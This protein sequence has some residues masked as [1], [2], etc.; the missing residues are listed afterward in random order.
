MEGKMKK[1]KV[2]VLAVLVFGIFQ[3]ILYAGISSRVQGNVADDQTSVPVEGA[4]VHLI[5]TTGSVPHIML[6][7]WETKTDKNGFFKFDIEPSYLSGSKV[8]SIECEKTGYIP[9]LPKYYRQYTK[10]EVYD[11]IFKIFKL[12]EGQ[13]KH[14][15]IS[16]KKGGIIEGT[17]FKKTAA[18]VAP[19]KASVILYSKYK[20]HSFFKDE[21][22]DYI[23]E[24]CSTDGNGKFR[25]EGIEAFD[26]YSLSINSIGYRD[27]EIDN[28]AVQDNQ[29]TPFE[30]TCDMTDQTGVE[31]VVKINSK[32]LWG[33]EVSVYSD[34]K[35][36]E[37]K[38]VSQTCHFGKN[39]VYA[40]IGI[41]PGIYSVV[42][43]V[44]TDDTTHF[45]KELKIEIV[46]GITRKL[47]IDF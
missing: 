42:I 25:I 43:D 22:E 36:A 38:V 9:F 5:I 13:I 46:S 23:F 31:G 16:L 21:D 19:L 14:F 32:S 29:V 1:V 24:S 18:G 7:D 3:S 4:L 33:G 37:G 41:L 10:K 20:V 35:N 6:Y 47:D 11:D 34:F 26:K 17:L 2:L 27:F 28:I 39:G 15:N 45:Q 12:K 8:F 30:Y 44:S 40:C